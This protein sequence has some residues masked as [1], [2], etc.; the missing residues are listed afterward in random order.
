MS[1]L[2][3]AITG[4]TGGRETVKAHCGARVLAERRQPA[5]R[6]LPHCVDWL[7]SLS[8]LQDCAAH[9]AVLFARPAA[10]DV[11]Y[12]RPTAA[13]PSS[14]D[15][16]ALGAAAAVMSRRALEA[17]APP[18]QPSLLPVSTPEQPSELSSTGIGSSPQPDS[19]PC[20]ARP[21]AAHQT[22][23]SPFAF[24]LPPATPE[25][26][27]PAAPGMVPPALPEEQPVARPST[28]AAATWRPQASPALSLALCLSV[29]GT[30]PWPHSASKRRA[31]EESHG[32]H[33]KCAAY[34]CSLLGC[35]AAECLRD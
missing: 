20:S 25:P 18:A 5:E 17:A 6:R 30:A 16:E 15:L 13:S 24:T 34:L 4:G 23:T 29:L 11:R 31:V 26:A 32:S 7:A 8:W 27:Q 28:D 19:A 12:A 9:Q 14:S 21:V 3:G 33:K 2:G 22:G 35:A 1:T 10:P